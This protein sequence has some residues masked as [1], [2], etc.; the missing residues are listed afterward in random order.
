MPDDE[1]IMKSR[2]SRVCSKNARNFPHLPRTSY[3]STPTLPDSAG[4]Q[5]SRPTVVLATADRVAHVVYVRIPNLR[6]NGQPRLD[7]SQ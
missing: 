4:L 6:P 1:G 7:E 2:S 3:N 5:A